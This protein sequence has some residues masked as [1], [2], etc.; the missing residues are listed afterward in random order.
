MDQRSTTLQ[1]KPTHVSDENHDT[2]K[3]LSGLAT[4]KFDNF[5]TPQNEEF[6]SNFSYAELDSNRSEIRLLKV[7][8]SDCHGFHCE[9]LDNI[10]LAKA[11]GRYSTVSY[12]AGDPNQTNPILVDGLEFNAFVNLERALA[13]IVRFWQNEYPDNRPR[14]LLLWVDQ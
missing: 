2:T 14:E 12:Y 11:H 3:N 4:P 8:P 10:T 6:Y 5:Y 1:R 9:L 7:V 13:Q